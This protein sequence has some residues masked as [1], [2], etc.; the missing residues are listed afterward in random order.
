[1]TAEE[2][3]QKNGPP[4]A[5][6]DRP[7]DRR[8]TYEERR[9]MRYKLQS[10]MR[11]TF[12]FDR[13]KGKRVL[14]V[15]CGSGL[16]AA[17]F[18][19]NGALVSACDFTK[20]AY[21]ATIDTF[22]EAGLKAHSIVRCPATSLQWESGSFDLVYCFG[23]LHH[24]PDPLAAMREAYR[25][26]KPGG[27]YAVMVYNLDSLLY[28]YSIEHLNL[29]FERNPGVPV[30]KPFF[31][32][33]LAEELQEVRFRDIQVYTRFNVIDV[34]GRRKVKVYGLSNSLGVGWHLI[35]KARKEAPHKN[36]RTEFG[37]TMPMEGLGKGA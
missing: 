7:K 4:W 34:P 11:S 33:Q 32:R 29:E 1:M 26:L 14:D 18:A 20:A 21:D 28:S 25:V 19:R 9:A 35:G 31:A 2:Y 17:E 13:W 22:I 8:P 23:V 37:A 16:D 10:Y 24:L 12:R 27:E 3:W 36:I 30:A 6:L 15:G 5:F